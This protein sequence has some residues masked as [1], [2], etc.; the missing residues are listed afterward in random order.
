M[1][2]SNRHYAI[3]VK[4]IGSA[5]NLRCNYCYY[6]GKRVGQERSIMSYEVLESY[7]R[8]VVE[9]HGECAEIE[10][11][12]HG[13]EPT[14]AGIPFYQ[15]ALLLQKRYAK[16]RRVLNTLQTNGTLLTDEWCKFFADNDFRIGISIDG[17]EQLHNAFRKGVSDEDTFMQVM[18]GVE[19]LRKYG[20]SYNTLT[21]VNAI[22]AEH[23][24]EVYGF[25]RSISNYMQ[26]LPV[27]ESVGEESGIG[28][29][30]GIY[31]P[32]IEKPRQMAQFNVTAEGYGKFLCDVL[33]EWRVNDIGRKFV[34][35]F[36]SA[37]GNITHR[38]AGLCV[39]EAVC[40]HCAV[41]EHNG[42]VYRCDRFV[43][44]E[45]KVGNILNTDLN[46]MMESNRAFGEYKLESLPSKCLHCDV[47]DICFGGCPKDRVLETMTLYG[48]ER[49]NYLCAGYKMFFRRMKEVYEQN[50]VLL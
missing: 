20:V 21:T 38:P 28:L 41:V 49:H 46:T 7:I 25:L 24:K 43:F 9:I 47:V 17:P 2:E 33:D 23:G 31:S 26:F 34:Q 13:G 48:V 18:R 12:W 14:L 8:Q 42:C 30:P 15:Q 36:E 50:I 35:I 16:G 19:L 39:H 44:D 32:N 27:V 6:L 3:I 40:G 45:Y 1:P 22:N 4:P 37:I 5:C 10:F 11:A 29:P